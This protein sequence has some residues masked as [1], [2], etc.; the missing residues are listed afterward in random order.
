MQVI[1]LR[2][3]SHSQ[4]CFACAILAGRKKRRTHHDLPFP[5]KEITNTFMSHCHLFS[6][7][8]WEMF[9]PGESRTAAYLDSVCGDFARRFMAW[10]CR[11]KWPGSMSLFAL[12]WLWPRP[13]PWVKPQLGYFRFS[14]LAVV[15]LQQYVAM[16][17]HLVFVHYI[18]AFYFL[19]QD[20]IIVEAGGTF[21]DYFCF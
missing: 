3:Q 2:A 10:F 18:N 1:T 13:W 14:V 21:C 15:S 9:V 16:R 20:M 7:G 19:G 5:E 11:R 4:R 17:G 8:H 12:R 6:G